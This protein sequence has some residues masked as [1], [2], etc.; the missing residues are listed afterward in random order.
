MSA[1]LTFSKECVDTFYKEVTCNTLFANQFFKDE[2]TSDDRIHE[3]NLGIVNALDFKSVLNYSVID[4]YVDKIIPYLKLM[5][6]KSNPID[7]SYKTFQL[8]RKHGIVNETWKEFKKLKE[9]AQ[10]ELDSAHKDWAYSWYDAF[11]VFEVPYGL[12]AATNSDFPDCRY[13]FVLGTL[14]GNSSR[15]FRTYGYAHDAREAIGTAFARLCGIEFDE[16]NPTKP[17]KIEELD[18]GDRFSCVF[19]RLGTCF[20]KRKDVQIVSE[21]VF[22]GDGG[23]VCSSHDLTGGVGYYHKVGTLV[24]RETTNQEV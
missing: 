17:T 3:L 16:C 6:S 14:F 1:E 20:D 23:F 19:A 12:K 21:K 11:K 8:A 4:N 2:D 10:K 24:I 5:Y 7:I 13:T 9:I 22:S 18:E 15:V